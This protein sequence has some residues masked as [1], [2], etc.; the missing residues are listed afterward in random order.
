MESIYKGLLK[1]AVC[2]KGCCQQIDK[3]IVY[4]RCTIN[5]K[6]GKKACDIKRIREDT[7]TDL[8][9]KVLDNNELST[10]L[11]QKKIDY[12]EIGKENST[13]FH[14]KDGKVMEMPIEAHQAPIVRN[15]LF[16]RYI[17]CGKCGKFFIYK[18]GDTKPFYI[19]AN[20]KESLCNQ[21]RVR[22][23]EMIELAKKV[24][25]VDDLN[26]NILED[27]LDYID[28]NDDNL[29]FHLKNGKT[30]NEKYIA[31]SRSES[32]TAE[33]KEKARIKSKGRNGSVPKE[34]PKKEAKVEK[35]VS[36][37]KKEV[38]VTK[39]TTTKKEEVKVVEK[40]S[41][42]KAK[43]EIVLSLT[44]RYNNKY[45]INND[46]L[47]SSEIVDSKIAIPDGVVKLGKK[48]II[49]KAIK[50]LYIPNT[51]K[52]ISDNMC[53]TLATITHL[54]YD[55]SLD[56]YEKIEF[57]SFSN[58]M[59]L[60]N[61]V[62]RLSCKNEKDEYYKVMTNNE[63]MYETRG[64]DLSLLNILLT[65]DE[66][67]VAKSCE[68][69][70]N[71]NS[72]IAYVSYY[73][74]YLRVVIEEKYEV[75][76]NEI[77]EF[78][79]NNRICI[80]ADDCLI[81]Y[82]VDKETKVTSMPNYNKYRKEY[83]YPTKIVKIDDR[84]KS[85]TK[86]NINQKGTG[87]VIDYSGSVRNWFDIEVNCDLKGYIIRCSDGTIQYVSVDHKKADCELYCSGV[88]LLNTYIISFLYDKSLSARKDFWGFVEHNLL[89]SIA[90]NGFH[91][92]NSYAC[93]YEDDNFE[94]IY[95]IYDYHN[96]KK[97]K[98]FDYEAG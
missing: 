74:D 75:L 68:E 17:K 57:V 14:L 18:T 92:M 31:P 90:S 77:K 85:I 3:N 95:N 34:E 6:Y 81:N 38:Q 88:H 5:K 45:V 50:E 8:V 82:S 24:L 98:V 76:S 10:E 44:D 51:V 15:H 97:I 9:K 96:F 73:N 48:S 59:S 94:K 84:T 19:C 30:I 65:R 61:K 26:A 41:P 20:V 46:V 54:Y 2:G 49:V 47:V 78:L 13:T 71:D 40:S 60:K 22:E 69:R 66:A 4:Y 86:D 37:K 28:C 29:I 7:L 11:L 25:D 72:F 62:K 42:K 16:S 33:M 52:E 12:I 55:G 87:R 36:P 91:K 83:L 67:K 1:C 79:F 21:S 43:E 93:D 23:D 53:G 27:K 35:I 63:K 39:V 89:A 32:W 56:D 64:I 70:L 80:L 58:W